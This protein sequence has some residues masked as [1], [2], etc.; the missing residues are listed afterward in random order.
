MD[1]FTKPD[2]E[3]SI[4]ESEQELEL[5][6]S[7]KMIGVF[8]EPATTFEK[9]SNFPPRTNDWLLP[10]IFMVVIAIISNILLMS[11]PAIKY[12]VTQKGVEAMRKGFDDAVAKG[13]MTQ[14]Q[15]DEQIEQM[16]DRME[17]MGAGMQIIQYVSIAFMTF[18]VFFIVSLIYFVV[19]KFILKGDGNYVSAMI[20]NGLPYYI[21]IVQVIVMTILSLALGRFFS[22]TSVAA[23]LETDKTTFM[24]FLLGK[25]DVFTIWALIITGIGL[26]KMFKSTKT[27][28]FIGTILGIWIVW[29]L[30]T[31]GIA[32]VV[33]FLSFL[34]G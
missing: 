34:A 25:L 31:F 17:S 19:S 30:I 2:V 1:D 4:T 24:G 33:P 16:Q 9:T 13:R 8:S 11:N 5:S 32:K 3:N 27:G 6:H 28:A 14:E 15:A 29:G 12:E 22:G 18:I 23:L 10:L 7:D 21:N 20:G 26:A